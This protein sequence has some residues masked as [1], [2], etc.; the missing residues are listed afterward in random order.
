MTELHLAATFGNPLI[1]TRIL[2]NGVS[3]DI[4]EETY[5][6]PL[7]AASVTGRLDNVKLLLGRGAN[8][9]IEDKFGYTALFY[10]ARGERIEA[11]EVLLDA[12]AENEHVDKQ[13]NTVLH[14]VVTTMN[15]SAA[16][17]LLKRGADA[18]HVSANGA[19]PLRQAIQANSLEMTRTLLE[20]GACVD[21][22]APD[23]TFP[24]H[25]AVK[26]GQLAMVELLCAFGA[27]V[28]TLGSTR[29]PPIFYTIFG[30]KA[31]IA[32]YLLDSS[33]KTFWKTT[34]IFHAAAEFRSP[35]LMKVF[36][37]HASK[38]KTGILAKV[39]QVD[40]IGKV[41][42]HIA[43]E[44]GDIEMVQI[45]VEAGAAIDVEDKFLRTPL[46]Y[47]IANKKEDVKDFLLSR[48]AMS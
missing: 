11:M 21:S 18:N 33:A 29:I 31:D 17:L 40:D 5:A 14:E 34:T 4:F 23:G 16:R 32:Q 22:E 6:T 20:N 47:A 44:K 2:D 28:D 35:S 1:C 15:T 42:L 8:I 37:S 43:A 41:P 26:F 39:N 12:G 38:S 9:K 30:N 25:M 10:A 46:H 27:H 13:G 3:V 48:G 19:T 7:H 45:L 24:L 36:L